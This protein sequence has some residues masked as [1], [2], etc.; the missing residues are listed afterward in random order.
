MRAGMRGSARQ[1]SWF[2]I[3][4]RQVDG[5]LGE[6][7]AVQALVHGVQ[8]RLRCEDPDRHTHSLALR[9]RHFPDAVADA[10]D[11]FGSFYDRGLGTGWRRLTGNVAGLGISQNIF[12]CYKFIFDN[13]HSRPAVG[14]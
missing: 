6:V 14:G 4:L 5:R 13:C 8:E 11:A 2:A 7:V 1:R 10:T 12:E 3:S 9:R